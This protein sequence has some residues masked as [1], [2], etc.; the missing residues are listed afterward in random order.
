MDDRE[1]EFNK[2]GLLI[3]FLRTIDSTIS[4]KA[5]AILSCISTCAEKRN[6]QKCSAL[7]TY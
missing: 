2:Y 3:L 5:I 4:I 1:K 7:L 6:Q